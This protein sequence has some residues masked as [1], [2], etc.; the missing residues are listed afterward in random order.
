MVVNGGNDLSINGH[1]MT[2]DPAIP[3]FREWRGQS[4]GVD[5]VQ[6]DAFGRRARGMQP[7]EPSAYQ[8]YAAKVHAPCIGDVHVAVDGL[9]DMHPPAVNR[10]HLA[11]NQRYWRGFMRNLTKSLRMLAQERRTSPRCLDSDD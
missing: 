6:I 8:I 10:D 3:R 2:L 1:L 4:H 11:G 5:I 9:L 7:S